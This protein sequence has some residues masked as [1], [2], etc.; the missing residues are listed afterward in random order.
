MDTAVTTNYHR[1]DG[2]VLIKWLRNGGTICLLNCRV[3]VCV[4]FLLQYDI[5]ACAGVKFNRQYGCIFM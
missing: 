4:S 2:P 5:C 3:C 1:I